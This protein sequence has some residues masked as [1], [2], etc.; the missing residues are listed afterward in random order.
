MFIITIIYIFT[1]IIR[2]TFSRSY[3]SPSDKRIPYIFL[4][5]VLNLFYCD[6]YSSNKKLYKYVAPAPPSQLIVSSVFILDFTERKFL[7]I[8]LD[9]TTR[10]YTMIQII[11]PSRHIVISPD[12]LKRIF[13]IMGNILSF[14]LNSLQ[15]MKTVFL[16]T[17]DV[18]LSNMVYRGQ[19]T[20]VVESKSQIGCRVLLDWK[21]F[22]TLQHLEWSI[23]ETTGR[24]SNFVK[25]MMIE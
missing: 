24:K 3:Y 9:P 10:F 18:T 19:N 8:G 1:I 23:F 6:G 20:L 4:Y 17:D 11:T 14:I 16:N 21:D 12:F 15:T 7:I 25:P 13:P 2:L 22:L 5:K